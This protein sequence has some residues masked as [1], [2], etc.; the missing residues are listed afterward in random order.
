MRRRHAVAALLLFVLAACRDSYFHHGPTAI[1]VSLALSCQ[2]LIDAPVNTT[3]CLLLAE[4]S[5]GGPKEAVAPYAAWTSSNP[6][7]A[8]TPPCSDQGVPSFADRVLPPFGC[9][10]VTHVSTGF[11]TIRAT[12]GGMTA[13]TGLSVVF[14]PN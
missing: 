4:W 2:R 12:F 7:V 13:A 8:T 9:G 14:V 11:T 1:V 5:D 3:P 6:D 10:I